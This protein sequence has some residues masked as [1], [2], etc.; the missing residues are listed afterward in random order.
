MRA[1]T[2]GS[3]AEISI[4]I[5]TDFRNQGYGTEAIRLASEQLFHDTAVKY[6]YAHIKHGNIASVR[7]FAKASYK[8]KGVKLIKGQQALQMTLDKNGGLSINEDYQN[9]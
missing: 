9:Q 7:G 4:S 3:K 2:K 8:E 5:S 6:I 1:D